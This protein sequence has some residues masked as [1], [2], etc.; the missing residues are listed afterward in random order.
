MEERVQR[1]TGGAPGQARA[2]PMMRPVQAGLT[3]KDVYLV[4]R[5]HV[6]LVIFLIIAGFGL[7]VGSWAGLMRIWPRYTGQ[8]FIRVLPPVEKDPTMIQTPMVGKDI[9][10]GHRLSMAALL[11]SQSSLQSLVDRDKIQQTKWFQGF[12]DIKEKRIRKA[13]KDLNKRF[14]ASPQ[15][16]GDSIAVSMTTCDKRESALIVNEMVDFFIR[17]QGG[18][19]Q[20]EVSA[21][22]ARL[23]EQQDRVNRDLDAAQR[24]LDDVRKRYGFSDLEEHNF[25]PVVESKLNDLELQQNELSMNIGQIQ[26]GIKRLQEQATGPVQVQVER[27]VE[28]DPVMTMLAQQLSLRESALASALARFGEDHRLV[29]QIREFI[30]AIEEERLRRKATIAEQTRQSNLRNAQDQLTIFEGRREELEKMREQ[31]LSQK[32]ELDMARAQYQ[33]RVA[34]RDE[35]RM[36]LDSIKEQIEK[37]KIIHDD[38]ETPKLQFV[39]LAPEPLEASFPRWEIF[40]PS[41]AVLGLLLGAGI[42][43]LIELLNDLVRMPRDVAR[44]LHI[45]LLGVIPDAA[46]DRQI[47]E[48]AELAL[49]VRQSPYSMVSESYRRLRT[50]LKLS[51]PAE[52]SKVLLVTSGAAGDGKTSTAV[53]LATTFVADDKKVLLIDANFRRPRLRSIF[54]PEAQPAE[55]GGQGLGNI[56]AGQATYQQ[57]VRASGMRDLDIIDAGALPPNPAELLGSPRMQQLLKEQRGNYDYVII[58]GPPVLLV[59]EAK[60]VARSADGTVLVFNAA[61]TRRGAAQRTISE[62]KDVDARIVGCVLLAVKTLKGGYFREQFKSYQEYLKAQVA[63]PA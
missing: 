41:G 47:E 26:A 8:T 4:L 59:S 10:Y 45:P 44:Y 16:D 48:D 6:W 11:K 57:V 63:Q 52:A 46:E 20:E 61:A 54:P 1:V 51:G 14:F 31:A 15:R 33:E 2:I 53:N 50:N 43:F 30:S 24:S 19:K 39:G 12:G 38:P 36:M 5:R 49:V 18:K 7:G 17:Q 40:F 27:Q 23:G 22:L 9:E 42:A 29:R 55:Q 32:K 37:L 28:T 60:M 21:K 56:L 58:D 3:A 25:Q 35:R 34:I 62:L 13:V